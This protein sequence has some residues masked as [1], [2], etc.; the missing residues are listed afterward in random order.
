MEENQNCT[1]G[2]IHDKGH[3][4]CR[5]ELNVFLKSMKDESKDLES[6]LEYEHDHHISPRFIVRQPSKQWEGT[7]RYTDKTVESLVS[8]CINIYTF[9]TISQ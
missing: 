3:I 6:E 4:K 5:A 1:G 9:Y 2:F 8:Q 7:T